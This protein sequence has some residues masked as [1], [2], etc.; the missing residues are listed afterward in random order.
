MAYGVLDSENDASWTWFFENLKEAYGERRN[1]CVVSYRNT[2]IIKA[3]TEVYNDVPHY[4][5]IWHLW[6]NVKKNFRKLHDALSGVFYTMIKSY[7]NTE[8]HGLMEKVE[9]V[10]VR[11]KNYLKLAGYDK[12]ARSYASVNRGWSLTSN[13]AELVNVALVSARE[14]PIYDFLE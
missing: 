14:L 12:W 11:V 1:M 6:G 2:S 8:F 5:C 3:L 10:D 13:I 7:S 9:A 4:A